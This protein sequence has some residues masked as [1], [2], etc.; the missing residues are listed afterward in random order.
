[1]AKDIHPKLTAIGV[2]CSGC[3]NS[4]D[5]HSTIGG[6]NLDIEVCHKCHPAYTGKRRASTRGHGIEAFN[7]RFAGFS[8]LTNVKGDQK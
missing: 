6:D 1:M 2:K 7:K 4:F 5:I 8:G 3:G